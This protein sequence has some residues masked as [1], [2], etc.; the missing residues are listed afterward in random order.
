MSHA[1]PRY[2]HAAL[3]LWTLAPLLL[4][5][6]WSRP[7]AVRGDLAGRLPRA[8][9][10]FSLARD[11][12]MTVREYDLLGTR[13]VVWRTYVD[14]AREPVYLI[15]VFHEANWKS[16]HPPHICLRGSDMELREDR[17]LR[18][19]LGDREVGVGEIVAHSRSNGRG[20]LSWFVFGAPDFVSPS[21]GAFVWRH[22]PRALLRRSDPGFL[23]RVETW[24]GDG[25]LV[26]ARERCRAFLAEILPAA[27]ASLR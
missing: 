3:I 9:K 4:F 26:A 13:D 22:V 20:Y 5:L 25:D 24:I 19:V 27:E 2:R 18:A 23:L 14:S 15:A 17:R 6:S 8:L 11:N 12:P 16:V 1:R 7:P 21:Y 10:G